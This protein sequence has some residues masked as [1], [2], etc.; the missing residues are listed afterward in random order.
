MNKPK[1]ILTSAPDPV[2]YVDLQ[3][4]ASKHLV[5]LT[6]SIY[7]M[8]PWV[9]EIM[10]NTNPTPR[11]RS[12]ICVTWNNTEFVDDNVT[13]GTTYYYWIKV[14]DTDRSVT[15]SLVVSATVPKP[16]SETVIGSVEFSKKLGIGWNAGNSLDAIGGE[17]AWDNPPL[18]QQLF[19]AVKAAGFDTVRLPVAWS[20]FSDADKFIIDRN[21]IARVNEVVDYALNAGLYVIVN[22]HWDG[23]WMQP[24]HTQ[25]HYVNNRLAIMWKQIASIFRDYDNRLLFAGTNEVMVDGDYGKPSEEYYTTQNSFNQTFVTTVRNTGGNNTN[26][27]L[28][29]QGYN[30]DID[31]TVN[32]AEIPKDSV[33]DRLMME[34]HYYDPYNFTQNTESSITQW[35]SIATDPCTVE[36]WASESWVDFQFQKM[37]SHFIDKGVAVI[38]GEFGVASRPSIPYNDRYRI[39]WNEYISHS[40]FVHGLVPIYWDS[41]GK[42]IEGSTGIFDRNN[43]NP[44]YPNIVKAL[45]GTVK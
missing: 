2:K 28:V 36:D 43:G 32:F 25:Q 27:Y 10:R 29:V 35:G 6:W 8:T 9:L 20:V 16:P 3:A 1:Q 14:T 18:T 5:R 4:V 44:L 12:R 39:Y 31:H 26:R 45:V 23:G 24:T 37:K 11:G 38:L 7:G 30:A 15:N 13:Q 42:G 34:V 17:T 22:I 40:A 21:W 19:C 33:A 41:G